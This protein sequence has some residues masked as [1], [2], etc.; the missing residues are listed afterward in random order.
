MESVDI[1]TTGFKKDSKT[2]MHFMS[3]DSYLVWLK[4][5][6]Q[7]PIYDLKVNGTTLPTNSFRS[8]LK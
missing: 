1:I 8:L 4:Y 5:N 2:N 6:K 7:R 3:V